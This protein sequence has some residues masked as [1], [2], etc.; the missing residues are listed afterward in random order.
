[1]TIGATEFWIN[2]KGGTYSYGVELATRPTGTVYVAVSSSDVSAA[3]VDQSTLRF[4][5][6]EWDMPQMVEVTGVLDSTRGDRRVTIT[7]TPSGGGYGSG[8]RESVTVTVREDDTPGLR[9]TPPELTVVEDATAT[10]TVELNTAPE[11]T[12]TVAIVSRNPGVATVAPA[13]LSFT[14]TNWDTPQQITVTGT[15]DQSGHRRPHGNH[16]PQV[17]RRRTG[18]R[19]PHGNGG[20]N[21][22]GG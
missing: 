19:R 13:S 22:H 9:M 10:Y 20:R 8:Q 12:V 14:T 7:H 11:G 4:R 2:E 1:M 3:T 16:H 6:D 15:D 21:G 18:L 5:P 17:Q